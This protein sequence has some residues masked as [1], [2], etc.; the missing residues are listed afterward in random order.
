MTGIPV[1]LKG[2]QRPGWFSAP[3]AAAPA[4]LVLFLVGLVPMEAMAEG[5][6]P[7]PEDSSPAVGEPR[8][9]VES[10]YP[11]EVQVCLGCHTADRK[12]A[13]GA[14]AAPPLWGVIGREP[15]PEGVDTERWDRASLERWLANPKSV[16]PETRSRFPGYADPGR[17]EKVLRFLEGQ[18]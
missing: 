6:G 1:A 9:I 3:A 12:R 16:A 13:R 7:G 10:R 4:L 15:A 8:E 18:Q 5:Q 17:R 11:P 2:G 14:K